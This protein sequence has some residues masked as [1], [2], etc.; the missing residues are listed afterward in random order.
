MPTTE[1]VMTER[2]TEE[3]TYCLGHIA[4]RAPFDPKLM[5]SPCKYCISNKQNEE[6]PF[7]TPKRMFI[8]KAA[9]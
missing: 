6:C 5:S 9:S 7:Y 8:S 1:E 3:T 4:Y 2:Q